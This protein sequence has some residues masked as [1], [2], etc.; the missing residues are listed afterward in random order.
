ML[1]YSGA[2]ALGFSLLAGPAEAT[3]MGPGTD[4]R[5]PGS[6]CIA[7]GRMSIVGFQSTHFPSS[8]GMSAGYYTYRVSLRANQAVTLEKVELANHMRMTNKPPPINPVDLP[9]GQQVAVGLGQRSG[10]PVNHEYM[11]QNIFIACFPRG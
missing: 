1:R 8:Q 10:G 4:I 7:S 9:S 2:L 3:T 6:D 5:G 11:R